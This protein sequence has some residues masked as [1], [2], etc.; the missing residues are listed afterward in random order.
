MTNRRIHKASPLFNQQ[1]AEQYDSMIASDLP[2]LL[3]SD[4]E[5]STLFNFI[6]GVL[7]KSTLDPII[8]SNL[9]F[10]GATLRRSEVCNI[11]SSG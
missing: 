1:E 2:V 6:D 9:P 4:E 5:K 11:I 10:E 7:S 3:Q 8:I